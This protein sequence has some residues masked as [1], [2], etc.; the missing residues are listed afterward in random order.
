MCAR[1]SIAAWSD[2][3]QLE[4]EQREVGRLDPAPW[5]PAGADLLVSGCFVAFARGE[6]GP[7][8]V[9]DRAWVG[10]AT[11]AADGT[12]V[13]SRVVP[14]RAGAAYAPGLLALREGPMVLEGV[15][16]IVDRGPVPDVVMLDATGRDHPR[17]CG[18]A[19]HLGWA[20]DI[21]T[22]GVTHRLLSDRRGPPERPGR[23][24]A[25][26][27]IFVDGERVASWV[28]T[29]DDARPVVAHAGWRT[30]VDTA[31]EVTLRTAHGSRTPEPLRAAREL[32]R[33]ARHVAGAG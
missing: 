33:V 16:E 19:V 6:A 29:R 22:V 8:A 26:E 11:L 32:A 12:C 13:A 30:D 2:P 3:E 15:S 27:P 28:W 21:P 20:L 24:G 5:R 23:R 17:R 10:V 1:R 9:G 25:S 14:A 18:L 4:R 31:A 7:G